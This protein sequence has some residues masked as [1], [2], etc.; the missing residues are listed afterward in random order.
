MQSKESEHRYRDLL[1]FV[2]YGVQE[3]DC[4]G[5]ITY[6]NRALHRILGYTDG[7][8][9]GQKIWDN[10]HPSLDKKSLEAY[11]ARLVKTRP[12]PTPYLT[13]NIKKNGVSV[14][15]QVDWDYS[16]NEKGD[17][18]GFVSVITD[19]GERANLE[20]NLFN[21]NCQYT[22]LLKMCKSLSETLDLKRVFQV[23]V[24]S[25]M[26]LVGLDTA[27]VYLLVEDVLQLWATSPSLP[28]EFPDE[29]RY[30]PLADHPHV[31]KAI[32]SQEPLY[33]YDYLQADL[34][35]AERAIAENRNLRTLLFVPLML[36][37]QAMGVFIVGSIEEPKPLSWVQIELSSTLAGLSSLSLKNARLFEETKN[38]ALRFQHMLADRIQ[39]TKEKSELE[40]QLHHAQR[41][42]AIGTLAGGVAHD[43]NN[44]LGGI[45]G[46]TELLAF[47]L[48][49][50]AKAKQL[51]QTI[52][53]SAI[54]AS[55]LTKQLLT[56]SRQSTKVSTAVNFHK[57]VQETVTL[58]KRTLDKRISLEINLSAERSI[59]VGD[60]SLL[61]NALLNLCIN[62]SQAMPEG[63]T[64]C[65]N[66]QETWLD[67]HFCNA[68]S[69]ELHPGRYIEVEVRDN[70]CG[71]PQENMGRIFEPFFTTK[72]KGKGTGLGLSSVYG[73]VQQHSGSITVYS[74][75]GVGSVFQILLPLAEKAKICE[76][77]EGEVKRGS[78]SILVVDDE[79]I[80]R[81]TAK[82]I[83][84]ALG[85]EVILAED[86]QVA[87]EL[88][89]QEKDRIDL[90][91]LDMIMPVMNGR[92]CFERLKKQDPQV[93]VILSSG[94]STEDDLQEMK[95]SGLKGFIHKPYLT[96]RLSQIVHE[97]LF[98][99]R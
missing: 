10:L 83:L 90:V 21:R 46:A 15:L 81:S 54:R 19:V 25:V 56:F 84:E 12:A 89:S 52:L 53:D 93:N 14:D 55:D 34:S 99:K 62:A 50:D 60:P 45:L 98:E 17:L 30:A 71:M 16:Y 51:H 68:S 26:E 88:F 61:H 59:I 28:P 57:I 42:E 27:A 76:M 94:F 72:E 96:S 92:E 49:D 9:I 85:Y 37:E 70:G 80:M 18:T 64:L 8:L 5:T 41:M 86:G 73:T 7:E 43:F 1:D 91:L 20:E 11:L 63:G 95:K 87:L 39:M 36:K 6:S 33:I 23:S 77:P 13:Q 67:E 3:N 22:S 97:V 2:K 29:M 79:E 78:G 38:N 4:N 48:P 44:M 65:L 74:E 69:F 75:K 24:D 66:T 35:S 40:S 32:K 82:A 58:I 47:Y 31:Q